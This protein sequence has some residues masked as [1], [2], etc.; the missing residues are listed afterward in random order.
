[1][2]GTKDKRVKREIANSN[3]RR[4]MQSINAGFQKLKRLLPVNDGERLSKA[5]ILQHAAEFIQQIER[6]KLVLYEQNTL[7]RGILIDIKGGADLNT[8]IG[9]VDL[10]ASPIIPINPHIAITTSHSDVHSTSN[11]ECIERSKDVEIKEE[12]LEN[13]ETSEKIITGRSN[14]NNRNNANINNNNSNINN[15]SSCSSSSGS[16]NNINNST[17]NGNNNDCTPQHGSNNDRNNQIPIIRDTVLKNGLAAPGVS[18]AAIALP[19][20]VPYTSEPVEQHQDLQ[21]AACNALLALHHNSR[22]GRWR[23]LVTTDNLTKL[24]K[25]STFKPLHLSLIHQPGLSFGTCLRLIH[26]LEMLTICSMMGFLVLFSSSRIIYTPIIRT[27]YLTN[28][29]FPF[30][31]FQRAI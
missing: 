8:A 31:P 25:L 21:S 1:M 27:R 26:R 13:Y 16:S 22:R 9:T 24:N 10:D 12:P 14:S 15:S 18:K 28:T 29:K 19:L 20:E 2:E 7:L 4:R 3:E 11:D 5:N 30:I 23:V 17:N 6:D